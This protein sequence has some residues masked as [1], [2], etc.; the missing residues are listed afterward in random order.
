MVV[1]TDQQKAVKLV[2]QKVECWAEKK[3]GTLAEWKAESWG[4][5]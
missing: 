2:V 1:K 4:L 5:Q 3:A